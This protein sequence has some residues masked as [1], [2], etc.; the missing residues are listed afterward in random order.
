VT[1]ATPET[2]PGFAAKARAVRVGVLRTATP[3]LSMMDDAWVGSASA[4]DW[5]W[6][7][8]C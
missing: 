8:S 3:A 7:R 4:I 2:G 5:T 1:F 6:A